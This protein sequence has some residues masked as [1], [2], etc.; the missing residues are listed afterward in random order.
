M[1]AGAAAF[2]HNV[3]FGQVAGLT[4][5]ERASLRAALQSTGGARMASPEHPARR[6]TSASPQLE[7]WYYQKPPRT[8][9]SLS[10]CLR[11]KRRQ[12]AGEQ[13]FDAIPL[14]QALA[15]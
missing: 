12:D 7:R 11:R 4:P 14:L 10:A 15:Q 3:W 5:G 6:S 1:S 13:V 9:E 8:Q 2:V